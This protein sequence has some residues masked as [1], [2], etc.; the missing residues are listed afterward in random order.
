MCIRDRGEERLRWL[1]YLLVDQA[2]NIRDVATV[3]PT[4]ARLLLGELL[5]QL[6]TYI[7]LAAGCHLP[8]RK[9]LLA[10]LSRLDAAAAVE[11]RAIVEAA[12][13]GA[14]LPLLE[15]FMQRSMGATTFFT[16]DSTPEATKLVD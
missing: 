5:P 11:L 14:A 6:A 12:D 4:L 3:D 9:E 10:G 2:D 8:R 13:L 15:A 1:R 16:W 7:F